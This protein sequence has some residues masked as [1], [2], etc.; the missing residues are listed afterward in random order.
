MIF[1]ICGTTWRPSVAN[2]HFKDQPFL[3]RVVAL[4][5]KKLIPE[6]NLVCVE[7]KMI[8]GIHGYTT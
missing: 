1:G 8:F 3:N 5:R 7:V 2:K 4:G 6:H